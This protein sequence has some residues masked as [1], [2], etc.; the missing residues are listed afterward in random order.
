MKRSCSEELHVK[1]LSLNYTA[2]NAS[3]QTIAKPKSSILNGSY[4]WSDVNHMLGIDLIYLMC[5][6]HALLLWRKVREVGPLISV[7]DH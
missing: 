1:D 5:V 4:Q 2:E 7:L 6:S 3:L